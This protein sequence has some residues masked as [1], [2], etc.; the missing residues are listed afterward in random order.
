M[1]EGS[2]YEVYPESLAAMATEFGAAEDSWTSLKNMVGGLT[3]QSGDLGLLA[4]NVGYVELYNAACTLVV[5]KL[6]L[7]VESFRST[8]AALMSVANTYAL[9]DDEYYE[10]LSQLGGG[11]D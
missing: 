1:A 6:G 5:E 4:T 11:D 3:M 2:G 9:Q 8:E 10:G 7:A